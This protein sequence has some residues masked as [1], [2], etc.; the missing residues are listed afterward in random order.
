MYILV[1]H[2]RLLL[3]CIPILITQLLVFA[4]TQTQH[5]QRTA[6]IF[7]SQIQHSKYY[8]ISRKNPNLTSD[9][10]Q[11]LFMPFLQIHSQFGSPFL[12]GLIQV[13]QKSWLVLRHSRWIELPIKVVDSV[14]NLFPDIVK[15]ALDLQ[16]HVP[17]LPCLHEGHDLLGLVMFIHSAYIPSPLCP[18]QLPPS[19]PPVFSHPRV[20]FYLARAEQFSLLP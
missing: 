12:C 9:F 13:F 18:L 7:V 19:M 16:V 11:C 1:D 6:Y 5:M 3:C 17:Y 15:D 20:P 8:G 14:D 10:L 4:C 2:Y